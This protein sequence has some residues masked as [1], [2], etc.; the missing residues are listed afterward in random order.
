MVA[1]SQLDQK[2]MMKDRD[3]IEDTTYADAVE[4]ENNEWITGIV[5][6]VVQNADEP[7]D[8]HVEVQQE[9]PTS[10]QTRARGAASKRKKVQR[11]RKKKLLPVFHDDDLQSAVSSTDSDDD[12]NSSSSSD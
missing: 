3:P 12:A 10:M 11:P 1:N 2:R 5:P 4:N 9:E 8:E 6:E 7:E